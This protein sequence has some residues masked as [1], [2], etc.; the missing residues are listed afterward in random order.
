[1]TYTLLTADDAHNV[2][3]TRFRQ[4]HV[5]N[6]DVTAAVTCRRGSGGGGGGGGDAKIPQRKVDSSPWRRP[7]E[8][9]LFVTATA[10]VVRRH[11]GD[12]ARRLA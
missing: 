7:D 11:A 12:Q 9:R 10:G 8:P 1:M 4:R 5:Q 6:V 2:V 3:R